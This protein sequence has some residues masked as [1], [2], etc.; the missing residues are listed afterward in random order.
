MHVHHWHGLDINRPWGVRAKLNYGSGSDS[1]VGDKGDRGLLQLP[2][3]RAQEYVLKF[4]DGSAWNKG[5]LVY[6]KNTDSKSRI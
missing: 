4:G 5:K 2:K 1:V 6:I 3:L